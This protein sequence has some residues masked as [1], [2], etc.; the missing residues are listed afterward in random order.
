MKK[1]LRTE[2]ISIRTVRKISK[3]LVVSGIKRIE[4]GS[5]YGGDFLKTNK[6]KRNKT[7]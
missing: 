7:G 5:V 2:K 3:V 4:L 1:N 6:Q